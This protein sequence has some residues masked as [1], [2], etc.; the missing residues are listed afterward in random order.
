MGT[1]ASSEDIDVKTQVKSRNMGYF[2]RVCTA[3][4]SLDT[5]IR[6]PGVNVKAI[7]R[8]IT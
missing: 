6:P 2:T 5:V 8:D 1:F 3:C 7:F 4:L